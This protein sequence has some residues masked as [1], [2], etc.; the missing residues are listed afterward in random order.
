MHVNLYFSKW[1]NKQN[2]RPTNMI[3]VTCALIIDDE[4]RIFAAQ[5]S[6]TMNLPFKW[7]LPG[8][9]IEPNETSEECL[10]REIKEELNI[11]IAIVGSL[12]SNIHHYANVSINLI[13]FVSKHT[14]GKIELKEHTNFKWLNTNELLDLDWAEADIPILV[15]YLNSL[16]AI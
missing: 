9:K 5:R 12:P 15:Q 16:N 7:E 8:G 2:E 1:R 13:P 14:S 6:E 3:N 11:D 10:V 4:D